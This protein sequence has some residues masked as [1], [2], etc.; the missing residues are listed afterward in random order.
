V[1]PLD[2]LAEAGPVLIGTAAALLRDIGY[3]FGVPELEHLTRNG[4]IRRR[5]SQE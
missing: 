2:Q 5:Y 1:A 4:R 3:S